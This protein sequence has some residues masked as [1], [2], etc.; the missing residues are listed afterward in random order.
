[1]GRASASSSSKKSSEPD[2]LERKRLKN[3]AFSKNLLSETPAKTHSPLSPSNFVLKHHGKDIIR[4]SQRKNKFLFSFPGLLAPIASGGKIGELKDLSTKN[5]ILYLNFPQGQ[6]KLFGTIVYPKNKYLGL[7]FSRGGKSAVCEDCFD[8]MIVFSEAWW[9]GTKEENPEEAQLDFPK[10]MIQVKGQEIQYDFKGG[11]GAASGNKQVVARSG[12]KHVEQESLDT[13]TEDDDDECNLTEIMRT[14][15]S[16]RTSGKTFKFKEDSSEDKS[17]ESDVA[18]EKKVKKVN[19][20]STIC[21][22]F[23]DKDAVKGDHLSHQVEACSMLETKSTKLAVSAGLAT[24]SNED[25]HNRGPLVQATISTLFSKMSGKKKVEEKNEPKSS[26][27]SPSSKASGRKLENVDS[28][29]KVEQT[30]GPRKRGKQSEGTAIKEKK[31]VLE[32]EDDDIEEF[33]SSTQVPLEDFGG[34]GVDYSAQFF[35]EQTVETYHEAVNWAKQTAIELGF[36]LTTASHKTGGKLRWILVKCARG[37]KNTRRKKDMDM[38]EVIRRNTKTKYCGCKFQIK[39]L[40]IVELGGW[41]VNG[42]AGERGQHNH[43]LVVYRQGY[44]QMSGLSPA[45]KKIVRQMSAAQAKSCAIF[46]T[47]KEK[48]P[49]DC[50]TQRHVYNYREKIRTESFEGRDVI[51][52]FYRLAIDKEYI[53]WTQ[54]APGSNVV[55]HLFMA[56]PTSITLFR[57]YYLFVGMDST[58]KTNKYKMPFF[59]IIGITPSNKNF[60]IA[61]AIM[62]DETEGS[63]MWVLEKLKLLLGADVHPTAI[64]TDRELGLMRPVR[65]VFPDTHHLL[66]IWHINKDVED[67]V[68]KLCGLKVFGEIF[69]NSKW[70]NIIEAPKVAE[71]EEAVISMKNTY[72]KWPRVIEY[73]ET[74]WL[75]HKEKFCR[76]WTNKVLHLGNT[77][78][79]RVE[80]SHAQLKQWLN[81]STGALDTV[82][83]KVH[84]DI[85]AQIEAIKKMKKVMKIG[86]LE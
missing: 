42:I 47:I 20:S 54:A 83:A 7:Q 84:K 14:R 86:K 8:N 65:E 74:T 24:K 26:R 48:H 22:D 46:A 66:C 13:E 36:E 2:F 72:A 67:R 78:T 21:L 34:N 85:E 37:I 81:S 63:Y 4:K 64:A 59:E 76:A 12:P 23:D 61:Y 28:K 10:D 29:R 50:P 57:S 69:K 45:S 1:M 32:V 18:E 44:R 58:Y 49:E 9:I 30:G 15:Q 6:M 39:V 82:W 77:T 41:V 60:L 17:G 70:K 55:T 56:H 51:S 68:G 19:T 62:K 80:S 53:H 71:Y 38:E 16:G 75:V 43:P 11:A 79:C 31:K 35:P 40:E 5:P 52:Q 73:V 33:S 3:L 27:K 25:S